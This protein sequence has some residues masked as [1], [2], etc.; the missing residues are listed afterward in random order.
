MAS[1]RP[2]RFTVQCP[3][4]ARV[5]SRSWADQARRIESLGYSAIT[6]PDHLD[7]QLGPVAALMAAAGATTT[8]RIATMVFCNDFRHPAALAKEAA[9]LD[10]LSD[11]RLELGIGAGWMT[12]DYA[13]AGIELD[14]PGVRIERLEEAVIIVKQLLT[15]DAC[16]FEG[17][18]YRVDGLVGS[19]TPVQQPVPI[20]IGGGGRKMLGVAARHADVVGLNLSLAAGVIDS[21]VGADGTVEATE[22]KLGWVRDA[23]GD[24]S[25]S[26]ELQVRVHLTMVTATPGER[27]DVAAALAGGFGLNP[28]EALASPYALVGTVDQLVDTLLERRDRWGIT[29]I[30]ISL[31]AMDAFAPVVDALASQP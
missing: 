8:L 4:A 1:D 19:P 23:A 25:D 13:Q 9:T 14:P 18:H 31:D 27:N 11:G 10:L 7:D 20:M 17:R 24:R 2:F 3:S 5:T 21:S 15:G 26:L 12:S 30:G 6:I 28:D 16:S 29:R 22:R